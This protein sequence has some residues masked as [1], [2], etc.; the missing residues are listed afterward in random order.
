[1]NPAVLTKRPKK[2]K[3]AALTVDPLHLHLSA[4]VSIIKDC[5]SAPA[6]LQSVAS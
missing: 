6:E 5:A 2:Q 1:M 4:Q 3:Q